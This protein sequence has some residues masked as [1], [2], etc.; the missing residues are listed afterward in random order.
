ME[1][2]CLPQDLPERVVVDISG[3]AE[4][5]DSIHVR[6]ISLPGKV[7]ILTTPDEVIVSA[8]A[9][10]VEEV[11]EVAPEEEVAELE[12]AEKAQPE[13]GVSED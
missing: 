11:V 12:V 8:M 1:V 6:D 3:L 13:E 9:A 10:R 5:G 2:E 4:P 7:E